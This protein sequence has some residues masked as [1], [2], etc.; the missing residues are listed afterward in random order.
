M[1]RQ[2]QVQM[3]MSE[4][5]NAT[6][7]TYCAQFDY[8]MSDI[9]ASLCLWAVENAPVVTAP[10]LDLGDHGLYDMKTDGLRKL[11]GAKPAKKK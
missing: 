10:H 3:K 5:E 11:R 7:R 1:S 2:V 9:L 6:L 8:P 4:A